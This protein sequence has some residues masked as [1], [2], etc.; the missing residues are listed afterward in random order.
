MDKL[1]RFDV[2]VDELINL[3]DEYNLYWDP[4][5][6]YTYGEIEDPWAQSKECLE[7]IECHIRCHN[8]HRDLLL[9]QKV[10]YLFKDYV[11]PINSLQNKIWTEN[12]SK[13]AKQ[14]LN[15]FYK[16]FYNVEIERKLWIHNWLKN[17]VDKNFKKNIKQINVWRRDPENKELD[18]QVSDNL[19]VD[20]K[21]AYY[22]QFPQ[23]EISKP[24]EDELKFAQGNKE[25]QWDIIF[26]EDNSSII[27]NDF[28]SEDKFIFLMQTPEEV[29]GFV[30]Q[31]DNDKA[32]AKQKEMD[33]LLKESTKLS[34]GGFFK[35]M[36]SFSS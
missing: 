12:F 33:D 26:P 1:S 3:Y 20:L 25:Y 11:C 36:F 9:L 22:K 13:E 27:W 30:K 8:H 19:R 7:R 21:D 34:S 32:K 31:D 2:V 35:R 10:G 4:S 24:T 15:N 18:I 16:H 29:V 14:R 17:N 6:R 5:K 28:W 23:V